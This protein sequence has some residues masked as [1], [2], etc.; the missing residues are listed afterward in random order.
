MCV[1]SFVAARSLK[2]K[3]KKKKKKRQCGNR[4]NWERSKP[5]SEM[6]GHALIRFLSWELYW[7]SQS[8]ET[9][10]SMSGIACWSESRTRDRKVASSIPGRSGGI[11]F[12][13]RVNFVCWLLFG[14]R[15]TPVLPQWHVKDPGPSAKSTGGRLHLNTHTPLTQRSRSGLTLPLSRQ[16]M[17]TYPET[18]SHATRQGTFG[19]SRPSSLSHCGLILA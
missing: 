1:V 11:I 12:L 19:H 17:G 18:R 4:G 6:D 10:R 3:K 9:P 8:N 13:S 15:S 14:V 7:G 16:S 5:D 2:K